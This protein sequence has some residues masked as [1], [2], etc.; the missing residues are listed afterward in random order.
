VTP[1]SEFR[2]FGHDTTAAWEF[3]PRA[4][5][6]EGD[7]ESRTDVYFVVPGRPDASLKLRGEALD[8]KIL[9]A[10]VDGLE[11]WRPAGKAEFPL[12]PR[13]LQ[14]EFLEPAGLCLDLP[15][16]PVGR[17]RLLAL[18]RAAPDMRVVEV[19]KRRRRFRLEGAKAE[20]SEVTVEGR[21]VR[22]VAVED[23][24][25]RAVARA[26]AAMGLAG[27][28]NV[29]Y[30]RLLVEAFFPVSAPGAGS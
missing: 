10:V 3:V 25:P 7:P 17:H 19:A 24:D 11:T 26:V 23:A 30:Q 5:A 2:V 18:A 21:P 9:D 16:A 6:R 27:R 20:L 14:A 22:S 8:L 13:I 28:R 29:S 12:A 1:R 15:P 4:G